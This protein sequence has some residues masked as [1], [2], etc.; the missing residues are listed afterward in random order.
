MRDR[1]EQAPD[2]RQYLASV[3]ENEAL[4]HGVHDRVKIADEFIEEAGRFLANGTCW[5]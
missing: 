2:F 5:R 1:Y 4:W 3:K